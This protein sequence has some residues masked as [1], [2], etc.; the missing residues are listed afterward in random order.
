MGECARQRVALKRSTAAVVTQVLVDRNDSGFKNPTKGIGGFTTKENAEKFINYVLKPEVSVLI[1]DAF[2]YTN[3]NSEAV[4]LLKPE[5]R[6]NPASYPVGNPKLETF[7]DI[8]KA[9]SDIDKLVTDL[10][11]KRK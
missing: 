1:S 2:P 11:A 3:P 7:K 6:E 10:K 4:K 8:G 5:Q 9:A